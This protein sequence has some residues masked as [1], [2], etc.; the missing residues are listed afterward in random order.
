MASY[1]PL[2]EEQLA[3]NVQLL[4]SVK[5]NEITGAISALDQGAEVDCG[6][7]EEPVNLQTPL[8]AACAKANVKMTRLLV[9]YNADVFAH[10]SVDGWTALHSACH[11]GH[12]HM[13]KLLVEEAKSLH[14]NTFQEGWSLLHLIVLAATERLLNR[15]AELVCWVLK[16]MP[17]LEVNASATRAGYVNWTPLHLA[18]LRG[19][20][21]ILQVLLKAKANPFE[22]TGEFYV[23]SVQLNR[24]AA[25]DEAA[26]TCMQKVEAASKDEIDQ[27]LIPLHLSAF[28]GH[29]RTCRALLRHSKKSINAMTQGH[30]WTPLMYGVWSNDVKLVRELCRVGGRSVVNDM[31]RRGNGTQW[32][33]LAVAVVR[34]STEMVHALLEYSADPLVR[35]TSADFPGAALVKHCSAL[36]DAAA[37]AWSGRDMR[38]SLLH[39]AVCRGSDAMVQVLRPIMKS[40]HQ[41][42]VAA[43]KREPINALPWQDVAKT[44]PKS[45]KQD[46]ARERLISGPSS[47]AQGADPVTFCTAEGWSPAVL[48]LFLNTVDPQRKVRCFPLTQ[49]W[50]DPPGDATR[51][52]LFLHLAEE[53]LQ[54][55]TTVPQ[56][57]P[58]VAETL[59]M[60][61]L[62]EFARLC[63]TSEIQEVVEKLLHATLCMAC[64]FNRFRVVRHLLEVHECDPRCSFMSSIERRPLH[65]AASCGH[66][67]VAQLLLNHRAD[68]IED[69][70]NQERP[71]LKLAR[72]LE[73]KANALQAR[74]A[75]LEA[76]LGEL[77]LQ[78]SP[79]TPSRLGRRSGGG[80]IVVARFDSLLHDSRM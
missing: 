75:Q 37:N 53:G 20:T 41:R 56:R 68:P 1:A 32:C 70:E 77:T 16:Q 43:S 65:I 38:I 76:A 54:P 40:A 69:D 79:K 57:F 22:M 36:P 33:P 24:L 34:S 21:E 17:K 49:F 4:R 39:L 35:L 60:M 67:D 55:D 6:L 9:M 3:L 26:V 73:G 27:G 13:A 10:F 14:E 7:V 15:G 61:T 50:P 51:E 63:K 47:E 48:A 5:D 25:G 52:E 18:A 2:Q 45:N 29:L 11:G 58:D 46:Q 72:A 12:D 30:C 66:G 44:M 78:T 23:S 64:H 8:R 28:G 71:V 19:Y 59:V 80:P 31:D 74:V 62:N 42:P